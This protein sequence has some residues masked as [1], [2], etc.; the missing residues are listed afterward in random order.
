MDLNN[1]KHIDEYSN[2]IQTNFK[3]LQVVNKLLSIKYL[4][5]S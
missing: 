4:L 1:S 5:S 3:S 2:M